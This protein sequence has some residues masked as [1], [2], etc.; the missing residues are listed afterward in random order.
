MRR[1]AIHA[2]CSLQTPL[3]YLAW[4]FTIQTWS[5][6]NTKTRTPLFALRDQSPISPIL[7]SQSKQAPTLT[8]VFLHMSQSSF[9][10]MLPLLDCLGEPV[11][12]EPR[13][14]PRYLQ[15]EWDGPPVPPARDVTGQAAQAHRRGVGCILGFVLSSVKDR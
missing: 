10:P 13:R 15:A 6:H 12:N 9:L 4:Y 2:V 5:L 8:N 1:L 14:S 11:S 3:T 7:W